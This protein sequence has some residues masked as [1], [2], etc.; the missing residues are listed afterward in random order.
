VTCL[1]CD[2]S[3]RA[4]VEPGE[5]RFVDHD[6]QNAAHVVEYHEVGR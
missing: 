3:E 4:H 5:E 6:R 1:S 2:H